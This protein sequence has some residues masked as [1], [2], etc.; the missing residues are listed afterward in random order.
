MNVEV[1]EEEH[2]AVMAARAAFMPV[3]LTICW[4][5]HTLSSRMQPA[6]TSSGDSKGAGGPAAL[7]VLAAAV[8]A[9]R[10]CCRDRPGAHGLYVALIASKSSGSESA[11]LRNTAL[12]R[13][14]CLPQSHG[15]LELEPEW[16]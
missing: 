15:A 4:S 10:C 3:V 2:I 5:T 8:C 16:S 13:V 14:L 1:A 7:S 6:G 12:V 9:S 11:R